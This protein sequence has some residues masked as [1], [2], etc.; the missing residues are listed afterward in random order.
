MAGIDKNQ[1]YRDSA[2]FLF[3]RP[4]DGPLQSLTAAVATKADASAIPQPAAITPHP[5]KTGGAKGSEPTRFALEDHQHP[6]LTSTTYA[7]LA[8]DG[9]ATVAFTRTFINQPGVNMTEVDAA[10]KQPLVCSVQSWVRETMT[11]TPTGAYIGCVIKGQ[12]AQML[13]TINPLSGTLTLVSTL[14]Q[15]VN[16]VFAQLT[17]YNIFGGSAAG[18]SVSII[19]VARSDVPAT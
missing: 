12:R 3:D 6:R 5:E 1:L 8:A 18:A 17:G 2:G 10:G 15:G 13:P 4:D 7:S 9:T 11:P 14:L 16:S 19:A